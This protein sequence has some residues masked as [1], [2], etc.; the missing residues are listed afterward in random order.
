MARYY[1]REYGSIRRDHQ[2]L[3]TV[4]SLW[5]YANILE[6]TDPRDKVFAIYGLLERLPKASTTA[7][8]QRN[9][10]DGIG[11]VLVI[12][13]HSTANPQ[14]QSDLDFVIQLAKPDCS[15]DAGAVYQSATRALMCAWP[16]SWV[17]SQIKH[18]TPADVNDVRY[19][20]W[21]IRLDRSLTED[22]YYQE[23][24]ETWHDAARSLNST[25]YDKHVHADTVLQ[26][27]GLQYDHVVELFDLMPVLLE[28]L[29]KTR[30]VISL[31]RQAFDW[32]QSRHTTAGEIVTATMTAECLDMANVERV[33]PAWLTAVS[34]ILFE[35][36]DEKREATELDTAVESSLEVR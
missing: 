16:S 3:R 12:K 27:E 14:R 33:R 21:A 18:S 23:V 8:R 34:A 11:S 9:G 20:S 28:Q 17:L 29:T 26:M 4:W 15:K 13:E 24:Y 1:D 35:R 5:C 32:T 36:S 2:G 10:L 25:T 30:R 31:W 19:A 22:A 7:R 6:T